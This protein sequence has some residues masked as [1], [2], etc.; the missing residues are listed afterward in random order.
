M[1]K[2]QQEEEEEVVEVVQGHQEEVVEE[3]QP[4]GDGPAVPSSVEAG[5]TRQAPVG[6]SSSPEVARGAEAGPGGGPA[7]PSAAERGGGVAGTSAAPSAAGPLAQTADGMSSGNVRLA[8][9]KRQVYWEWLARPHS[10]KQS[11]VVRHDK[12]PVVD[13][14]KSRFV[15][16]K[17]DEKNW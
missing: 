9:P 4:S 12:T 6:S 5:G 17:R 2:E 13:P 15:A 8:R 3:E 7:S 11:F 10:W 14:F 1:E 16:G